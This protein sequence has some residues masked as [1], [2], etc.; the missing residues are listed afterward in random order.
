MT[1]TYTREQLIQKLNNDEIPERYFL[2]A[3]KGYVPKKHPFTI[4]QEFDNLSEFLYM[5]QVH[6]ENGLNV[7]CCA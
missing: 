3:G 1:K 4:Y 5:R 2:F 7:L 6:I